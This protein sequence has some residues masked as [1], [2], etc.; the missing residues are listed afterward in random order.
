MMLAIQ[1]ALDEF[2]ADEIVIALH[3]EEE[4]SFA[5]RVGTD[6]LRPS[7]D[8]VRCARS[9][10]RPGAVATSSPVHPH[11]GLPSQRTVGHQPV[12]FGGKG[13]LAWNPST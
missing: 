8:G 4:A 2:D 3:P 11:R 5:E 7:V 10:S 1:D 9:S 6:D 13:T 12:R